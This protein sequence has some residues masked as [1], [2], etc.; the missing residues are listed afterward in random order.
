V[1][2][3]LARWFICIVPG[4]SFDLADTI[5]AGSTLLR[6]RK[7][8]RM[9]VVCRDGSCSSLSSR[10]PGAQKAGAGRMTRALAVKD[11]GFLKRPG[12]LD[13][14]NPRGDDVRL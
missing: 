2:C 7:S 10:E 14:A 12:A 13:L 8:P 3:M 6:S 9:A 4:Y 11:H 1:G 5:D